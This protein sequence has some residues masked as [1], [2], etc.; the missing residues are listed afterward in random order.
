VPGLKCP[1]PT[2]AFYAFPDVS[3]HF[4]KTSAGG[5]GTPGRKIT[6]AMDFC[7]ALLAEQYVAFVPG[8]DFGGCG[9]KCARISFACS[10]DQINKGVDRL[11]RFIAG[12]SLPF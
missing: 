9:N 7:E 8:E 3:A 4:G 10:V 5:N 12:L 1:K 2:G 11:E 6:S